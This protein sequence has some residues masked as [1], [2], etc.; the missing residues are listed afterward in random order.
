MFWKENL[1]DTFWQRMI[2]SST[3][4]F[5]KIGYLQRVMISELMS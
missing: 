2:S 5:L 3:S 1:F 4:F